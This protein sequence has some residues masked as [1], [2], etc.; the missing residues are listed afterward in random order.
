[1]IQMLLIVHNLHGFWN[2]LTNYFIF[3]LKSYLRFLQSAFYSSPSLSWRRAFNS[4]KE[5]NRKSNTVAK[6]ESSC[7][8]SLA[9]QMLSVWLRRWRR[10]CWPHDHSRA[11][12][13]ST[14]WITAETLNFWQMSQYP[15][16]IGSARQYLTTH[17][18]MVAS[19][20]F[21]AQTCKSQGSLL[22]QSL[23]L[24]KN[25]VLCTLHSHLTLV[26]NMQTHSP[27]PVMARAIFGLW[28]TW[29]CINQVLSARL[30]NSSCS[31]MLCTTLAHYS[32]LNLETLS[33]W[34]EVLMY[35]SPC[36]FILPKSVQLSLLYRGDRGK[37]SHFLVQWKSIRLKFYILISWIQKA[38]EHLIYFIFYFP[39]KKIPFTEHNPL[40][41]LEWNSSKVKLRLYF[42][43]GFKS[44]I[45]LRYSIRVLHSYV[46]LGAGFRNEIIL[47]KHMGTI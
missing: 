12:A 28:P 11:P 18:H 2:H 1:M 21:L 3:Y 8:R 38:I 39:G 6:Q 31:S 19:E 23:H 9:I 30:E 40:N 45:T 29:S 10:I 22:I 7:F 27:W 43:C 47:L 4:I 13:D 44:F 15:P 42:S 16:L 20:Y 14:S 36:V 46:V 32:K 35:W 5:Q 33:T 26:G 37:L 34:F 24:W 17:T 41:I 25:H